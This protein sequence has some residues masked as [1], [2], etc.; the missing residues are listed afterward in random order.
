[1]FWKTNP[2]NGHLKGFVYGGST[3]TPLDGAVVQVTGPLSRILTN[4]G[5]G[6]YGT[7]DLPPGTYSVNAGFAGYDLQTNQVLI[8][9]GTV[10]T[11]DFILTVPGA[12]VI[13][14]QPQTRSVTV[15]GNATFSV[16]ATGTQPLSYQWRHNGTHLAAA[17][18]SS[19]T[20]T[21]VQ[22]T[23]AGN[24]SALVTNGLGRRPAPTPC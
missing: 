21:N 2:T 16:T 3:N 22:P 11:L 15:G 14:A 7:V 17:T 8:T 12:P 10:A 4:D 9:T 23:N 18:A 13:T 19:L 6:F 5:T 1:M 24:Y 20:L